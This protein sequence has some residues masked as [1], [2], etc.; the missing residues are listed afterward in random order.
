MVASISKCQSYVVNNNN[1]QQQEQQFI[2]RIMKD[3]V[4][5]NVNTDIVAIWE[6][7][8]L[9]RSVPSENISNLSDRLGAGVL[10]II[11]YKI[12]LYSCYLYLCY[13]LL[14]KHLS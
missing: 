13:I 14:F 10:A 9:M 1:D 3:R 12:Y 11:R 8:H 7:L 4:N 5:V 6:T 2:E